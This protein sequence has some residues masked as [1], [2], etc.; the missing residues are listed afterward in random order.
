MRHWPLLLVY[1][2]LPCMRLARGLTVAVAE[3]AG[4]AVELWALAAGALLP[5]VGRCREHLQGRLLLLRRAFPGQT[6]PAQMSQAEQ[7]LHQH[8]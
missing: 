2:V 4:H 6:C 1:I 3:V 8:I 7:A 5:H